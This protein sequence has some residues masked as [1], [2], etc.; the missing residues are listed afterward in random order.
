MGYDV[1][2][3]SLRK[4]AA[5]AADAASQSGKVELGAALDDVGPAMPG[6]RSG[7]AAAS[8]T[9]AWTNLVKSWS[10][11]ATAYGENLTAAADHY[12]ANEQ[13]AKADF[14]GVG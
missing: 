14:Q 10:A 13:A 9:T 2:I 6:S 7:P 5:A 12:A 8:L 1:V 11:D 4:A 3:D